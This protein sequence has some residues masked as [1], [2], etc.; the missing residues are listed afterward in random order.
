ML[1]LLNAI[2]NSQ[3]GGAVNQ[4]SRQFNLDQNQTQSALQ[5]IVPALAAGLKQNASSPTGLQ[6]LIG[7]ISTGRRQQRCQPQRGQPGI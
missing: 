6:N 2:M 3:Q 5:A 4:L 7:A 1:D